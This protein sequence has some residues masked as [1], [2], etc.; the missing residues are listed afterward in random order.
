MDSVHGLVPWIQSMNQLFYSARIHPKP[1][2]MFCKPSSIRSKMKSQAVSIQQKDPNE[3]PAH[4]IQTKSAHWQAELCL[5]CVTVNVEPHLLH[6]HRAGRAA[7]RPEGTT[8]K[9]SQALNQPSLQ[10]LIAI[11]L[12]NLKY[13][14]LINLCYLFCIFYIYLI[15]FLTH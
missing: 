1:I 9:A 11:Y 10:P 8:A 14:I 12:I 2:H 5:L 3:D 6:L 13:S 4:L 15:S 7:Q